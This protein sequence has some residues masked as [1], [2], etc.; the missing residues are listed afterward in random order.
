MGAGESAARRAAAEAEKARQLRARADAHDA[1][2]ARQ[3][4]G[5]TGENRL[6]ERLLPLVGSGY[7]LLE[8]RSVP[9]HVG[10]IDLILIGP[11]GVFVIDAKNWSGAVELREG[12]LRQNG[13]GRADELVG[14]YDQAAVVQ[15]ALASAGAPSL[16]VWPVLC[17][18]G[19]ASLGK[20]E[21]AGGVYLCSKDDVSHLVTSA[22]PALDEAW[23]GWSSDLVEH[24]FPPRAGDICGPET[25][26][27]EPIVF[28]NYWPK[29]PRYYLKDEEG[30]QGGYLDLV[31]GEA[32]GDSPIADQIARQLMPHVAREAGLSEPDRQGLDRILSALKRKPAVA[33]VPL[34]VGVTWRRRGRDR[35]YVFRLDAQG[36]RTELGWY[37]RDDGR[38]YEAPSDEAVVRYCG[39]RYDA[40][41]QA[42]TANGASAR[43]GLGGPAA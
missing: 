36:N 14:V 13:F 26:P 2:A 35:L 16:P 39:R 18:V 43:G 21:L 24:R 25:A 6:Y 1:E 34:V 12:Q 41:E 3:L 20:I 37:D 15:R 33:A 11:A 27:A 19:E 17:L 5:A 40:I 32:V 9:H 28:L 23:V 10:N 38:V 4:K 31:K 8:D 22:P 7:R 42:R 29:R 30:T